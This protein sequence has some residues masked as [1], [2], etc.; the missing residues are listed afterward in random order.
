LY[1]FETISRAIVSPFSA[2]VFQN[3]IISSSLNLLEIYEKFD[4]DILCFSKVLLDDIF[5]AESRDNL[6]NKINN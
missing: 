1:H 6:L 5:D 2:N 3:F 4:I